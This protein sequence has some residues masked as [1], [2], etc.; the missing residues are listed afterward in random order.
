M[1]S[2][3]RSGRVV[4]GGFDT[5]AEAHVAAAVESTSH[6]LL[7]PA[8][9]PTTEAD[10]RGLLAW[11]EGFGELDKVGVEGTGIYGAG[12]ARFLHQQGVEVIE[13]DRPDRRARRQAGKSDPVDAEA[14]ARAV[15]AGR[16]TT[17]PKTRDG[18]VE[19]I[20]VLQVVYRSAVKDRIAAINRFHALVTT[21]PA[22]VRSEA[23]APGQPHRH[24]PG[25]PVAAPCRPGRGHCRHPSGVG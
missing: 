19:A 15:L 6:R 9:F 7:G 25:S 10:Y 22:P 14:A 2:M 23:G 13:V 20:R 12:L 3:T 4:I 18:T 5:H 1:T 24:R 11:L 8:E 17:T 21:A 16:V